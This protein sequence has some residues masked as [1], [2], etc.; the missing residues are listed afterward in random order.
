M[1]ISARERNA[2]FGDLRVWS[3]LNGNGIADAGELFTLSELGIASLNLDYQ[4]Q[5]MTDAK[6]SRVS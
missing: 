3:D 5:N 2:E 1:S 6:A 4:A